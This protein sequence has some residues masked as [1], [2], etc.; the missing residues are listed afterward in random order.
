MKFT[1]GSVADLRLP[2]GK[3]DH[4]EPDPDLPNFGIRLRRQR[5]GGTSKTWEV[6]HRVNRRQRRKSL[7]DTRRIDLEDARKIARQRF[8][9]VELGIDPDAVR[10]EAR[11]RAVATR[12]T[13]AVGVERYLE[14]KRA[15]L[16][17]STYQAAKRYLT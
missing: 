17:P 14:A 2:E 15:V 9:Q 12:L 8:A 11:A 7:G 6:L 5:G 3:N 1:K 4:F 10:A 13:V 16:R